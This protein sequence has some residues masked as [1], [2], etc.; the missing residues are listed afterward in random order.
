MD[1]QTSKNKRAFMRM[2]PAGFRQANARSPGIVVLPDGTKVRVRARKRFFVTS[3]GQVT[4]NPMAV[5][6]TVKYMTVVLPATY[7]DKTP[8]NVGLNGAW[9]KLTPG[10]GTGILHRGKRRDP[11]SVL[12]VQQ[13][14]FGTMRAKVRYVKHDR[15]GEQNPGTTSNRTRR[16]VSTHGTMRRTNAARSHHPKDL[17]DAFGK[18]KPKPKRMAFPGMFKRTNPSEPKRGLGDLLRDL[19]SGRARLQFSRERGIEVVES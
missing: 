3:N 7:G 13:G 8:A 19:G 4:G 17:K 16:V 10:G 14:P 1:L 2:N 5:T 12:Q 15:R 9:V 11:V 18:P 6:G